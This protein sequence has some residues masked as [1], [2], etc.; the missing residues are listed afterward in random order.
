MLPHDETL[1]EAHRSSGLRYT[2][3]WVSFDDMYGMLKVSYTDEEAPGRKDQAW[4]DWF[5]D[6]QDAIN[7]SP[8]IEPAVWQ[9]VSS[10]DNNQLSRDKVLEHMKHSKE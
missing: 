8:I 9:K 1:A 3:L 7:T 6:F 10:G 5:K 4:A 2:K